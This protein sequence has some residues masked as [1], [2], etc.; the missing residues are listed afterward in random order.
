MYFLVLLALLKMDEFP[1]KPIAPPT[2]HEECVMAAAKA[3]AADPRIK[4]PEWQEA[5]VRYV[6]LKLDSDA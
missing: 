6:C 1:P 3:N 2:S 4:L 5:G